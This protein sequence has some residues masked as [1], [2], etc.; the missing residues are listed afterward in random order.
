LSTPGSRRA[1]AVHEHGGGQLAPRED[2]VAYGNFQ[3]DEVLAY[4]LVYALVVAADDDQVLVQGEAVGQALVE[5]LAVGRHVD[6]GLV[7]AL[8]L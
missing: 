5:A 8:A 3:G 1:D 7:S 6:D 4:A 2:V